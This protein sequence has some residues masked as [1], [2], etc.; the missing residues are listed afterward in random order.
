MVKLIINSINS[1]ILK[2][3]VNF[4]LLMKIKIEKFNCNQHIA[5]NSYSSLI[6]N[7]DFLFVIFKINFKKYSVTQP[8]PPY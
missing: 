4:P 5:F 2:M 7:F 3:R 6:L 1:F 8:Q